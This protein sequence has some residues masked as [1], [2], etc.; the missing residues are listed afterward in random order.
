MSNKTLDETQRNSTNIPRHICLERRIPVLDEPLG[1]Y[2]LK[3]LL[4]MGLIKQIIPVVN[5]ADYRNEG[6]I[7]GSKVRRSHCLLWILINCINKFCINHSSYVYNELRSQIL[8]HL[9]IIR[10]SWNIR[11]LSSLINAV[12]ST[13]RTGNCISVD[14]LLF[15]LLETHDIFWYVTISWFGKNWIVLGG[16]GVYLSGFFSLPWY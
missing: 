11:E 15:S 2:N 10:T 8:W 14:L 3:S 4:Q 9:F 1:T 6:L 16:G 13:L 7:F 12:R 5:A